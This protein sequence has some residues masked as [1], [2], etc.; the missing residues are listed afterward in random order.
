MIATH[1]ATLLLT[2]T[3]AGNDTVLLDFYA[4]WCG[5]CRGM[6]PIVSQL[7]A[8]GHPIRRVNVSQDRQ[9]AARYGVTNIPCYVLVVGGQEVDR[10]VGATSAGELEALLA[11]ARLEPTASYSANPQARGQSPDASVPAASPPSSGILPLGIGSRAAAA[12]TASAGGAGT[13]FA[14]PVGVPTPPSAHAPPQAG[15]SPGAAASRLL[16]ATV[17]LKI[18]DRDG[19]S[20]GTGTIIDARQGEA[21]IVTCGH[22]FRDSQ[23]KGKITVDVFGA[24][25]VSKLEGQLVSYGYDQG[26]RDVGLVSI[27]PGV[28]VAAARIAPPGHRVLPGDRVVSIGCDHGAA[29]TVRESKVT[30]VNKFS[31]PANVEVAGQPVQGRSGG[32][33]F[34]SEGYLVGVC[35]AADPMDNEGL[36]AAVETL[37]KELDQAHLSLVYQSPSAGP[38][39]SALAAGSSEG[40]IAIP[41][42][43]SGRTGASG[44][45]SRSVPSGL[46]A[47]E[48]RQAAALAGLSMAEQNTLG[49]FKTPAQQAEV[50]CIVRPLGDPA[51]KSEVVVLD[52]AS[53]AFLEQ[54]AAERSTQGTRRLTSLEVRRAS[55]PISAVEA[56]PQPTTAR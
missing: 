46:T 53:Q 15:T 44:P 40:P 20:Y 3:G 14:G 25:P 12:T 1:L 52:R 10:V 17:R 7:I 24:Q 48:L 28:P 18:E 8:A 41:G 51:A 23:G 37:H 21:L 39:A 33:L 56:K 19:F 22:I 30:S 36:F 16:A 4:D 27:R 35:N 29:P 11:K 5:P 43:A 6:E 47:D 55:G 49:Q 32:G 34:D 2:V 54:L 42:G 38:A 31:G 50:I 45:G 26:G 9:L 13:S